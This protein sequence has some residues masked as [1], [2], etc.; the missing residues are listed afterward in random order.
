MYWCSI[1]V[2]VDSWKWNWNYKLWDW[3]WNCKIWVNGGI[4]SAKSKFNS[5]LPSYLCLVIRETRWFTLQWRHNG[6]DGV[7][8]QPHHCLLNRVFRLRSKKTSKLRVTGLC[9]GNSPV[10]GEFPAQRVSNAENVPIWWRHHDMRASVPDW[11][12]I[13]GCIPQ[14]IV[15]YNYLSTPEMPVSGTKVL[16]SLW[17]YA[18]QYIS[19]SQASCKNHLAQYIF[20]MFTQFCP[21]DIQ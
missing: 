15:G 9:E 12:G 20:D 10:T 5:A 11:A 6:C 19:F 4:G 21:C 17:I 14:N 18:G 13:S 3:N 1:I 2:P 8:N 16:I 7:S